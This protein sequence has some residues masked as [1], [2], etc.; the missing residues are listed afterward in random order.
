VAV[1]APLRLAI[2][3]PLLLLLPILSIAGFVLLSPLLALSLFLRSRERRGDASR[4][5][6][7]VGDD[8]LTFNRVGDVSK[9]HGCD[10]RN[11][12]FRWEIFEEALNSF[13][14][15]RRRALD[16][17]AGSLRDS[18]ELAQEGFY[19]VAMDIDGRQLARSFEK[20]DWTSVLRVPRL[21]SGTLD[22][23]ESVEEFDLVIA[24]DVLEHLADLDGAVLQLRNRL[25]GAGLLFVS[26]PNARTIRERVGRLMHWGRARFGVPAKPGVPHVNFMSPEEWGRF[27][28]GKGL[29]IERHSMAI[30]SLV[31]DW[32][33]LQSF[34]LGVSGL[35]RRFPNLERVFCPEWF[36]R[37]LD[38]LDQHLK[39][40]TQG[41]WAW[42]LFVLSR[43]ESKEQLECVA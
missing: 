1:G 34:P 32:H 12:Q 23:L 27:F 2:G 17:G 26:V 37:R 24:F 4:I 8:E 41:F 30:G 22:E 33:F 35:A 40:F 21:Y 29:R 16:F 3:L 31:N 9:L 5:A 28:A 10:T 43:A 7:V 38:L 13:P 15:Q 42:N 39:R 11:V 36:M 14:T 19:V 6:R 18:W 25:S 20:Y